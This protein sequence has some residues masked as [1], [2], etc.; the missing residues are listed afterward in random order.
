MS[1]RIMTMY[2]ISSTLRAPTVISG[3]S[4]I[5]K[6]IIVDR[7]RRNVIIILTT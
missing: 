5:T 4:G 7:N 2:I 3:D 1:A 6:D